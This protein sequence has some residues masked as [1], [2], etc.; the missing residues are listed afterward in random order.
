MLSVQIAATIAGALM[1]YLAFAAS[2]GSEQIK[3]VFVVMSNTFGLIL[4]IML[5][6]YGL[7]EVRAARWSFEVLVTLWLSLF[8]MK[9][10]V[11]LMFSLACLMLLFCV[12]VCVCCY[13]RFR[14]AF[15]VSRR[16]VFG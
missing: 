7:V 12:I 14:V 11:L 10:L 2:L 5:L 13:C 1:V 8:S 4:S 6:G 3:G 16:R 9:W 15:G